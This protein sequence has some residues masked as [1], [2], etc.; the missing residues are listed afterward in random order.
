RGRIMSCGLRYERV[1]TQDE[2]V[3]SVVDTATSSL[4][5]TSL[6]WSIHC[7]KRGRY[8]QVRSS[9]FPPGTFIPLI[10]PATKP[11]PA[12]VTVGTIPTIRAP[13]HLDGTLGFSVHT[14]RPTLEKASPGIN[15]NTHPYPPTPPVS[16]SPSSSQTLSVPSPHE[17][18][19]RLHAIMPQN[20]TTVTH[21]VGNMTAPLLTFMDR[22][23]TLFMLTTGW[24]GINKGIEGQLG[25]DPRFWVAVA[26]ACLK[27]L[28]E[29][30]M[31]EAYPY[32]AAANG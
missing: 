16:P 20:P 29:R 32:L 5:T 10:P 7:P 25:V 14:W 2:I 26:L 13:E 19:A 6:W 15:V 4:F 3:E 31:S 9:S 8:L 24:L 12:F 1:M 27:F 17:I 30:D 11:A 21:F 23:P 22:T 28:T 18:K